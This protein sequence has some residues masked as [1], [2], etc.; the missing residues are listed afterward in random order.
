MAIVN[1]ENEAALTLDRLREL[2]SYDPNTGEFRW[3]KSTSNRAP[4]GSRAGCYDDKRRVGYVLIG[5]DGR[6]FLAHRV[7]WFYLYEQW[8]AG[9]IDHKDG[10]GFNNRWSNL[11]EA[12]HPENSRN[13]KRRADNTTGVKGISLHANNAKPYQ[14]W[15][16]HKYLGSFATLEEA[17]AI[18][19]AAAR[20]SHG[21]FY[22]R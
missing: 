15:V 6:L 21:D 3:L 1:R 22:R 20:Q 5:I 2:L 13:T 19:D 8:P 17:A 12:T 16:N 4:A 9:E 10:D 18:R 14:A 7:A 11:R